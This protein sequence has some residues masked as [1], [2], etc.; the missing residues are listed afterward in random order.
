MDWPGTMSVSVRRNGVKE[1]L[2][3]RDDLILEPAEEQGGYFDARN[4]AIARPDLVAQIGKV[5]GRR[6]DLGD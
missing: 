3:S 1:T 4:Q 2:D 6:H 5:F